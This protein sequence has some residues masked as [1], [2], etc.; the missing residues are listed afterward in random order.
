MKR[1]LKKICDDLSEHHFIV[2]KYNDMRIDLIKNNLCIIIEHDIIDESYSFNVFS[3][4]KAVYRKDFIN[5]TD[6]DF[7]Y[8]LI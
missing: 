8:K 1:K 3:D 4:Y 7:L 6:L 2:K 5:E